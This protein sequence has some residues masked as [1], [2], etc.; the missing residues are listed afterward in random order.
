MNKIDIIL[1]I[2]GS[3]GV[4]TTDRPSDSIDYKIRKGHGFLLI[5]HNDDFPGSQKRDGSQKDVEALQAYF[6]R[7]L[8]FTILIIEDKRADEIKEKVK[9]IAEET[10]FSDVDAFLCAILSH[11]EGAGFY[12]IDNEIIS[13]DE[14]V[15]LF[16]GDTL[17]G[18]PKLFFVQACRGDKSDH[19]TVV[20]DSPTSAQEQGPLSQGTLS[21]PQPQPPRPRPSSSLEIPSEADILIAHSSC[22]GYQSHRDTLEG[23]WFIRELVNQLEIHV[24]AGKNLLDILT[25]VKYRIAKMSTPGDKKKQMP[26]HQ[27]TLTRHIYFENI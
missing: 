24:P 13:I 18:K 14:I 23:S 11:G 8:D 25:H 15:S 22:D 17:P 16:K 6:E 1:L 27:S 10:D 26:C 21:Q 9:E 7:K 4:T 12:G 19:G 2:I 3:S 20:C 5:I